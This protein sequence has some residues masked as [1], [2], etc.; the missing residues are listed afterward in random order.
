MGVVRIATAFT[1][2]V[3]SF[4]SVAMAAE[5][6]LVPFGEFIASVAAAQSVPRVEGA[7]AGASAFAAMKA[8][9][10]ELYADV[11]AK[12]VTHSF[13]DANDTAF[14]CIPIMQQPGLRG[15]KGPLP[16]PPHLPPTNGA[17]AP[18]GAEQK[19]PFGAD[20]KDRFGNAMVCSNGTIPME[21]IT[22]E[23][24][25]RFPSLDAFLRKKGAGADI[26]RHAFGYQSAANLGGRSYLNLWDP[27]VRG[28]NQ[29]FSRSQHWYLAGSGSGLQSAEVGW[30]VWYNTTYPVLF[31][32]WTADNYGSTGCYNVCAAGR[33]GSFVQLNGVSWPVGG[34]LS[35]WSTI[36]GPQYELDV[37]YYLYQGNWWL[38]VQGQAIGY[39]PG[40]NYRGGP[41]SK[42]A[43]LV[44]YG[45]ETATYS[46]TSWP[47]MGSG[48]YAS[49]GF[50]RAAYQR[51]ITYYPTT[52]G[53]SD[54]RLTVIQE[55]PWD[56]T[57]VLN[58]YNAPWKETLFFGGPGG[59]Y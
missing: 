9:I 19:N 26:H 22:L 25:A 38:F 17:S 47:P 7:V 30:Q 16:Q 59:T 46:A 56:Y 12:A 50:R 51:Q 52:G 14:D 48:N 2:A 55:A 57:A 40:S 27:A 10:M 21:R 58:Y 3:L 39:Y 41:L 20:K 54:A 53:A 33:G 42:Y 28:A 49:A 15:W 8:Y 18:A 6:S 36:S 4:S 23:R 44:E 32:Y 43:T 31:V 24:L 35:P 13:V 45:G 37:G 11:D 5:R 34:A 29:I 1:V